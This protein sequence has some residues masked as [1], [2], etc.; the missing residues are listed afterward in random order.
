MGTGATAH[1]LGVPDRFIDH[2]G[3]ASLYDQCGISPEKIAATAREALATTRSRA[4]MPKSAK[5]P[6]TKPS[7]EP[8]LLTR[9]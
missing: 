5:S 2:G 4:G 3:Q 7:P 6:P 8:A 1:V 9:K